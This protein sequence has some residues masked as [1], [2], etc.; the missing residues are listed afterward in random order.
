[1]KRH[2]EFTERR[3]GRFKP[4]VEPL[5]QRAWDRVESRVFEAIDRGELT[6]PSRLESRG[7][8]SAP[9]WIGAA[10]LLAAASVLL[11]WRFEAAPSL[12]TRMAGDAVPVSA[13]AD[14][15]D[16][17]SPDPLALLPAT[18]PDATLAATA[19]RA[20]TRI[21]TT[22]APT[23]TAIGEAE[24][25]LAAHSALSFSG[26]DATGWLLRL[27]RG[28]VDCHVAPRHGRPAFIV[29][30]GETRVS[31]VGTR[32]SVRREG[33]AARVVVSEGHVRVASGELTLMLGPGEQWPAPAPR[34]ETNARRRA[35]ASRSARSTASAASHN[36]GRDRFERAARLEASDPNAALALYAELAQSRGPWSAN[37]LYAQARL[38]FE[39]GAFAK[40]EPLLSSYLRRHPNGVNVGDVRKILG[41]I[42]ARHD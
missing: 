6:A 9:L 29:Q 16:T 21:M 35:P 18:P 12:A 32:F 8:A 42:D 36:A 26:S 17:K 10:A 23:Q 15:A 27:E 33:D 3:N 31:V 39:R 19:S 13:T 20:T 41:E 22:A 30:G 1:M 34:V 28:Q 40:A 37:A 11:W 24:V 38:E 5:P 2:G 25:T 14:N 7:A 4:G